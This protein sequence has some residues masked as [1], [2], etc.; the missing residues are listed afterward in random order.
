M[1]NRLKLL[2]I[3]LILATG[4]L[5]IKAQHIIIKTLDSNEILRQLGSIKKISFYDNKIVVNYL[6]ED[7]EKFDI[8]KI[9][10]IYFKNGIFSSDT[11]ISQTYNS[12]AFNKFNDTEEKISIYPNPSKNKISINNLTASSKISIYSIQGYK[13][14]ESEI[15]Q[16]N[17]SIDISQ[18]PKGFYLV[19]INDKVIKLIKQ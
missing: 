2:I 17:N 18:F 8:S 4:L 15:N 9:K 5:Q 7:E 6:N 16:S 19:K 12:I 13:I 10:I 3:L 11:I 14:F 1:S